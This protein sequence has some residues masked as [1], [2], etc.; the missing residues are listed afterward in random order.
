MSTTAIYPGMLSQDVELFHHEN[1][2]MFMSAG[3][4]K[5][6]D[7]LPQKVLNSITLLLNNE[8][9]EVKAH[10]LDRYLKG[11]T[12][13]SPLE[14][15]AWCRFGGLDFT[16]DIKVSAV[17]D[18]G[19]IKVQ[20]GEYWNCPFREGCAAEGILCKMPKVNGER[21]L[22]VEV[23]ILRL[24]HTS[25]TNEVIAEKLELA[26]GTYHLYKKRLYAKMGNLLTRHE[27]TR[28]AVSLNII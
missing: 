13:S 17:H 27:V 14:Q 26:L 3:E 16:P 21:L 7:E 11:G 19:G 1:A 6:F 25:D 10:A 8:P 9:E 24:L 12:C 4:V 22:P 2:L 20:D 15:Y 5:P 23:K 28:V 18:E